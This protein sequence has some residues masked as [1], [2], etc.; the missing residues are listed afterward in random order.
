VLYRMTIRSNPKLLVVPLVVLALLALSVAAFAA[1]VVLGIVGVL[2]TAWIGYALFRFI[3]KQLKCSVEVFEG[4]VR[5]DLYGEEKISVEW[6]DVTLMGIASDPRRRRQ[7]YLYREKGDKLLVVPDE[8]ERFD[9]LVASVGSH[10][11]LTQLAL[12]ANETIKDRLRVILGG[13][14]GPAE[15]AAEG[16]AD[17]P[18]EPDDSDDSD[19]PD[20]MPR[21]S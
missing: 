18:D 12:E 1:S 5:L 2:L 16:V 14:E 6:G 8:F 15:D 3:S 11:E 9:E 19:E 20:P 4:G 10:G 7:L 21:Q 17:E 13:A